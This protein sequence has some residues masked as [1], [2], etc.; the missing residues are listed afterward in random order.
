MQRLGYNFD[1]SLLKTFLTLAET[2]NFTRT[3]EAVGRTQSAVSL[4]IKKLEEALG[5]PLLTRSN[6]KVRLTSEGEVLVPYARRM[7]LL[8]QEIKSQFDEMDLQGEIRLGTPE[9]FATTYLPHVLAQFARSHPRTQLTVDCDLT[10]NLQ[11]G[12]NQ[13]LYDLVLVK[14][15]PTVRSKGR[16]VWHEPLVW[17]SGNAA[18]EEQQTLPLVLSPQ[19][20]LYR[21]RALASLEKAH[22]PWRVAYTSPSLA[23][24][25]AA[26]RAGLGVTVLPKAMVPEK[27]RILGPDANLP[28]LP[29]AEI[30]LLH[31]PNLSK[32]ASMLAEHIMRHLEHATAST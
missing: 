30:A 21:K 17:V 27:L 29:D 13:G 4:Q 20:C 14:R 5:K 1:L 6:K 10:L 26:V 2:Q 3:A 25:V 12:F 32:P 16:M 8:S 24:A 19:P 9:D 15:E 31:H 23:G 28:H 22:R 7:I 11:K 18:L